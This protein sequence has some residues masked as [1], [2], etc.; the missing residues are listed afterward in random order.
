MVKP[1]ATSVLATTAWRSSS[2]SASTARTASRSSRCSRRPGSNG[3]VL[4]TKGSLTIE[5][6]SLL[7]SPNEATATDASG[8]QPASRSQ[9]PITDLPSDP[10]SSRSLTRDTGTMH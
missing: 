1:Q 7:R 9:T 2:A 5:L 8:P 10:I 3:V 6:M 4:R